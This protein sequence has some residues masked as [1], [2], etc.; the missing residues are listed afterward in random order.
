MSILAWIIVGLIGGFIGSKLVNRTGAG[1]LLD[2]AIGILGALIGGFIMHQ[3]GD[4]GVTG[5]NLWSIFVSAIGSAL[6]LI[7]FHAVR[8][9]GRVLP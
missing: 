9:R 8:G 6:F 5:L 7:I 1:A 2:I 3:L 4:P